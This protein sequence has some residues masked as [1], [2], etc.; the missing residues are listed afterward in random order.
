MEYIQSILLGIVQGIAE[1]LPISSSGHLVL[2]EVLLDRLAGDSALDLGAAD[3]NLALNIA[4]HVGTLGSIVVVYWKQLWATLRQPRLMAAIVV[5]TIPAG[6]VGVLFKDQVEAIFSSTLAVGCALCYTAGL[7]WMTRRFDQGEV[8]LP[9]ISLKQAIVVGLFQAVALIPG[10]SRAGSTIVG[11]LWCGLQREAAATFSFLIAVPAIGGAA[12]L[13]AKDLL[14]E[15]T[16]SQ[17]QW[18]AYAAGAGVS[19]VVGIVALQWL[20][21]LISRHKLHLFAWY[22]LSIGLLTIALSLWAS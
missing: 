9:Q 10:V 19:F 11:G 7:L 20:L 16:A 1:F 17:S 22:C 3:S 6:V 4:L 5:A 2:G 21:T 8:E 13:T 14:E 18:L 15:G 12:V